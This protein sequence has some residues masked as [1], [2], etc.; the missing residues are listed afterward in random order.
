MENG[1]KSFLGKFIKVG[2]VLHEGLMIRSCQGQRRFT[3]VFCSNPRLV[4]PKV[5]ANHEGI[6]T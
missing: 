6:Y 3:N 1:V 5:L 4:I 2:A